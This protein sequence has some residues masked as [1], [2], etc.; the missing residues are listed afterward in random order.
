MYKHYLIHV[1]SIQQIVLDIHIYSEEI[2]H[3]RLQNT[4]LSK[5]IISLS[6]ITVLR[7][8]FCNKYSIGL[9]TSRKFQIVAIELLKKILQCSALICLLE[10]KALHRNKTYVPGKLLVG[11]IWH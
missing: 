1:Y 11:A 5:S 8:A 7:M 3:L 9:N 10:I 4:N 6:Q 2:P